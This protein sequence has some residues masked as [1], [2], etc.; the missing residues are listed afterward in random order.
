MRERECV[1]V[2]GDRGREKEREGWE[3]EYIFVRLD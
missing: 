2:W 3:T 1:C